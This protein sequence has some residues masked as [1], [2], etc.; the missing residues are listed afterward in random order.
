MVLGALT[1]WSVALTLCAFVLFVEAIGLVR[2]SFVTRQARWRSCLAVLPAGIS[3]WS[4]IVAL[5]AYNDY[6]DLP[7]SFPPSAWH[8]L[9]MRIAQTT[10]VCQLQVGITVAILLLILILE[11]RFHLR[12]VFL[13]RGLPPSMWSRIRG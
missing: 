5:N 12:Y 10:L 2:A 9:E 1:F 8:F 3:I 6:L 4:F 11:R 13:E 7:P